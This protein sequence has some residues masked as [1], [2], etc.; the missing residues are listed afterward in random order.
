MDSALVKWLLK[1]NRENNPELNQKDIVIVISYL[2][3][4][5]GKD[6]SD[7]LRYCKN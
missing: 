5:F 1:R 4:K 2:I 3:K 6:L 7:H